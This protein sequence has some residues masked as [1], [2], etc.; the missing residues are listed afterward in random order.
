[1]SWG[2]RLGLAGLIVAL[3]GIAAFYLWPEKKWI[4]WLCVALAFILGVVWLWLEMK[5]EED[6]PTLSLS[7]ALHAA[8]ASGNSRSIES[9]TALQSVACPVIDFDFSPEPVRADMNADYGPKLTLKVANRSG[10][11]IEDVQLQPTE[12]TLKRRA[13]IEGFARYGNALVAERIDAGTAS[14]LINIFD[15]TAMRIAKLG[16][17]EHGVSHPAPESE[18]FYAL[19][20][21][22]IAGN[23][24]RRFAFYK[25]ISA[26]APYLLGIESPFGFAAAK[27]DEVSDAAILD[28]LDGP[29]KL[30]MAHQ[31]SMFASSP[32]QEYIPGGP[33]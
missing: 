14:N 19:R 29:K 10:F 13:A 24:Q 22:F 26:S 27:S 32:E 17:R 28:W 2:S 21:I 6:E 30:I 9:S 3:L 11:A 33:K 1:M 5:K 8:T 12:Y 15:L 23:S 18:R 4:G 31:R 16:L 25:I 7:E 20:F